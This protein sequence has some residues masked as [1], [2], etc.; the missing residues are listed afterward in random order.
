M[1]GDAP[2]APHAGAH[3][4]DTALEWAHDD[5]A[6]QAGND[7]EVSLVISRRRTVHAAHACQEAVAPAAESARAINDERTRDF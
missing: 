6:H 2:D 3:E 5:G 7:C 1:R 4:A